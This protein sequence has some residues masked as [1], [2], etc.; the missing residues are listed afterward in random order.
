VRGQRD[1]AR[2]GQGSQRRGDLL[3][4]L[5]ALE[6]LVQRVDDRVA[7]HRDARLRDA[8]RAQRARVVLG[9]REVERREA[10]DDPPVHLLGKR[11][12]GVARAEPR[13]DVADRDAAREGGERA[14]HRGR[15]VALHEHE[16][17]PL[18]GEQRIHPG[19][20][21]RSQ[22]G[23]RLPRLH[24]AQVAVD[25]HAELGGKRVE[26]LDV[27][28]RRDVQRRDLVPRGERAQHRSE[29]DDLGTRPEQTQ[30][31]AHGRL[32]CTIATAR[33]EVA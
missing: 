22:L 7:G 15:G 21:A 17:G 33:G 12:R 28:R 8:F 26:E 5:A 19:E 9:R 30:D 2:A 3:S 23:R 1:E 6:D 16:V 14:R 32:G 4:R 10:R 11:A 31:P 18:G 20:H 27:L 13:L 29:L 25:P 24:H